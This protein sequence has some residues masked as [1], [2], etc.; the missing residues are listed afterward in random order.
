[1][2]VIAIRV[3]DEIEKHIKKMAEAEG[4]SISAYCKSIVLSG[5]IVEQPLSRPSIESEIDKLKKSIDNI[6]KDMMILS[7]HILRQSSLNGELMHHVL[8][9]ASDDV[10]EKDMI[11]KEANNKAEKFV[12]SIFGE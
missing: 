12:R 5:N 4:K 3:S 8:D 7:K 6:N 1:M 9:V 10:E 11:R 2:G